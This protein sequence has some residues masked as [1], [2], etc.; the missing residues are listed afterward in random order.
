MGCLGLIELKHFCLFVVRLDWGQSRLQS[1][2]KQKGVL[3]V[4]AVDGKQPSGRAMCSQVSPCLVM[5]MLAACPPCL[6]FVMLPTND[7]SL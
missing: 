2:P 7:P 4:I 3:K 5:R 6:N 1:C